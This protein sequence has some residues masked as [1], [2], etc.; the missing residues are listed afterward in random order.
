MRVPPRLSRLE[1]GI[2][3]K[4]SFIEPRIPSKLRTGKKR[5][6]C[7]LGKMEHGGAVEAREF[8]LY[9]PNEQHPMVVLV[10]FKVCRTVD[11]DPHELCLSEKRCAAK[12]RCSAPSS[13][14][15]DGGSPE[16]GAVELG[17]SSERRKREIGLL[18]E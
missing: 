11:G 13:L 14:T 8:E 6:R 1:Y 7:E 16:S 10:R 18:S 5:C 4:D 9:G 2:S 12:N 3:R 17:L 15:E